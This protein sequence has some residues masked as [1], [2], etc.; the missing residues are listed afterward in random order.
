MHNGLKQSKHSW[1]VLSI[2]WLTRATLECVTFIKYAFY[3][4]AANSRSVVRNFSGMPHSSGAASTESC[5]AFLLP[6]AT[7]PGSISWGRAGTLETWL[8]PNLPPE[9]RRGNMRHGQNQEILTVVLLQHDPV[10]PRSSDWN[11]QDWYKE[12][13]FIS[14]CEITLLAYGTLED[15]AE[16]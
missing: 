8:L 1:L 11:K 4:A 7:L 15:L 16:D 13:K 5:C 2:S 9:M 10:A 14:S 3:L 6:P 12:R